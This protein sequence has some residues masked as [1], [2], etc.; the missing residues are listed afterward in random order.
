MR[1]PVEVSI[2]GL[3]A[4]EGLGAVRAVEAVQHGERAARRDPE[5][6]PTATRA[7]GAGPAQE[8]CSVEVPI[9]GLDQPSWLGAVRAVE[10]VQRRERAAWRD[11][12]D[13][14]A[15]TRAGGAGPAGGSRPVEVPI[16][17][18]D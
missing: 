3:Q 8:R 1:C 10:T 11:F 13:R 18:L 16:G 5:D 4:Y 17:R 9:A 15:A 7:G 2:G 14:A 6:G 12:E